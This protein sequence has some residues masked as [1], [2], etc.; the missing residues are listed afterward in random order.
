MNLN[1]IKSLLVV[2]TLCIFT[3]G[4]SW[5]SA[6]N[7]LGIFIDIAPYTQ[8]NGFYLSEIILTFLV[9]L[10]GSFLAIKYTS[11]H[12]FIAAFPVGIAGLI[13]YYI[14]LGGLD[15]VG[16]CGMPFWYD[17]VSFLKHVLASVLASVFFIFT[18]GSNKELMNNTN[19]VSR[20]NW[21]SK[22]PSMQSVV[23]VFSVFTVSTL[24]FGKLLF[25]DIA[26]NA[27]RV[28]IYSE[29]LKEQRHVTVF[30]PTGYSVTDKP[31]DVLYT[32]DGE[33]FQ[34]NNLAVATARIL[35]YVN[36]IPEIIVVAIDGQGM[37]AR[38]FRLKGAID[39]FG[40]ES[41]G[42]ANRFHAFLDNELIPN[43][44]ENFRTGERKLIAGHSYGGLFTAYSFTKHIDSFDGYFSFSP[45]FQD[46]NTSISSFKNRLANRSS[47]G[48]KD[49]KFIY[50]NLGLEGGVMR[51]SFKEAEA[52]IDENTM[53]TITSKVSYYSLPHALIMIPGYFEALSEFYRK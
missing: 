31:Y 53:K 6:F 2:L 1:T 14:E 4:I 25:A 41:S 12:P 32:L 13:F 3:V 37:R 18:K 36:I 34:H 27:T 19:K 9:Y 26:A 10:V 11:F 49:N 50:L 42:D 17:L 7:L 16:V 39:V 35:A 29:I 47:A 38:D 44:T 15:C 20:S 45:S 24:I 51:A 21:L 40:H 48:I 43:I 46:S 5:F 8:G 23:V 30:V 52:A 33:N 28:S 22:L